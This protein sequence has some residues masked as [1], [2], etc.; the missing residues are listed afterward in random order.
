V[1]AETTEFATL[2]VKLVPSP[3][4]KAA[5]SGTE[6]AHWKAE[7]DTQAV[8]AEFNWK[9]GGQLKLHAGTLLAG[10]VAN[11]TLAV[12]AAVGAARLTQTAALAGA[13]IAQKD[14]VDSQM[15][16]VG[17]QTVFREV[18]QELGVTVQSA[19]HLAVAPAPST[20]NPIE[21]LVSQATR[22]V[23]H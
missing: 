3:A 5:S 22:G 17:L 1:Q 7:E 21:H 6:P 19:T 18:V 10:Q 16:V 23:L 9:F 14:A 11:K 20:W 8:P 15:P 2:T 12:L 4:H 13:G